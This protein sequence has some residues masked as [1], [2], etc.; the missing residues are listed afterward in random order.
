MR[1]H[2]LEVLPLVSLRPVVE[3]RRLGA[4][5]GQLPL[6]QRLEIHERQPH[7]LVGVS[8]ARARSLSVVSQVECEEA[9]FERVLFFFCFF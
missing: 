3:M 7:A 4:H 6:L 9:H 5:L 2:L 8:D 1:E